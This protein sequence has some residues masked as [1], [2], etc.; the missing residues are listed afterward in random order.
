MPP[1]KP[2]ISII[3]PILD[4]VTELPGLLDCLNAQQGV[5]LEIILCDGGSSDDS[6][7][8]TREYAAVAVHPITIIAA[9]RGRGSQMNSGA[10]YAGSGLL[11]F[12]HADSRFGDNEAL[13]TAVATFRNDSASSDEIR[14]ARFV[15][16]FQR[17]NMLPSLAYSFY[18][19][20][21]RLNRSDCIRGD[22]GCMI[23]RTAFNRLGR[24]DSSLPF[25][26]DVRFAG[27]VARNGSW[28]LLPVEMTTSARRF[29]QEG[30]YERQV[31]NAIIANALSVG[32]NTFFS[33]LPGLYRSASE[34][35]RIQ[36]H[37]FLE[38]IRLLLA[39][40]P[41]SWRRSFWQATGRHVSG[42]AWQLFFWLDVRRTFYC[43]SGADDV[44]PRFLEFYYRW[45]APLFQ[46]GSAAWLAQLLVKIWFRFILIR[47]TSRTD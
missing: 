21:A 27:I 47:G 43:G 23:S 31:V 22:Q 32:W 13:R 9:P 29:E 39:A 15:L 3:V 17:T 18:E 28:Q 16:R 25:L 41:H 33:D 45:L 34:G 44:Q 1:Q 37:P 7:R 19:A 6:L 4:E 5:R 36:L 40:Q 10:E 14:A 26:E 24:F 42:N 30:L 20:K 38:G 35:G 46:T 8:L 2:D 12:L 11:L